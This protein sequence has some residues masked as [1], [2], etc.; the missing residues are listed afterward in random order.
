M[1]ARATARASASSAAPE[2]WHVIERRRALAVGGLLP[3]EVAR[4]RLDAPDPAVRRRACPPATGAAPARPG[5]EHEDRVVRA[6]CR[7][8]RSAGPTSGRP[9]AGAARG[10]SPGR[11]SR[12]SA[13]TDS[14]VA[15]RGWIIP[16]PLAMPVT[17]TE[18]T[19]RPSGSGRAI[20]DRRRLGRASRSSE[21]PRPRPR[22]AVVGRGERRRR[23]RRSPASTIVDRQPRADDP[24]RQQEGL[25]TPDPERVRRG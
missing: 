6:T 21:A 15:I 12:R 19:A 24:G 17:R 10:A 2:T 14:I 3:R 4:D 18:R 1:T 9:P 8:R 20:V 22:A 7:H 16:T 13:M 23:S 5:R 25:A 11:P